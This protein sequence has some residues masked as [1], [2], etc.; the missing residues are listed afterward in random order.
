[1]NNSGRIMTTR[2]H[3]DPR[4]HQY[5]PDEGALHRHVGAIRSFMMLVM[6]AVFAGLLYLAYKQYSTPLGGHTP[7]GRAPTKADGTDARPG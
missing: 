4:K 6:A 5:H 7:S 3:Q 2:H 1:M